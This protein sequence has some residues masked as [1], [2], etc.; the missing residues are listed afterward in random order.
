MPLRSVRKATSD[1]AITATPP[2][3]IQLRALESCSCAW[4]AL[5][6]RSPSVAVATALR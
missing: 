5:E 4:V 6:A 2:P 3:T 1:S